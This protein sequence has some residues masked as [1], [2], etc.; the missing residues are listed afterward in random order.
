[1]STSLISI[2]IPAYNEEKNIDLAYHAIEDVFT[3]K[4]KEY[5]FEVVFV[6]DGS[7]DSTLDKIEALEKKYPETVRVVS[8][9][10]NFGKEIAVTAG[11]HS[12]EGDACILFDCDLQYP[13]EYIPEFVQNWSK[14]Y[15]V[16]VGLR[17][18]KKEKSTILRLGSMFYGIVLRS[19]ANDIDKDA[20][21]FRLLDRKVIDVFKSLSE[22]NRATRNLID[23]LGFKRA[24]VR[25]VE[26]PRVNGKSVMDLKQR[27]RLAMNSFVSCSFKPLKFAGY[28]GIIIT[29]TSLLLAMV[30]LINK[31]V[32]NDPF[33][34][35][36]S[37]LGIL[38][39][40][41][42]FFTGTILICLGLI[43]LY[44][45]N[46]TTEVL[47]RPLYIIRKSSQKRT[48]RSHAGL[49][50]EELWHLDEVH[51]MAEVIVRE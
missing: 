34:L 38:T 33:R 25:Y 41:N 45:A 27:T 48:P 18:R 5:K 4:L 13:P 43:A 36:I 7:A 40:I 21:D 8:L 28:L 26:K 19:I 44:I 14:G 16:V 11:I 12:C 2:I 1:M 20:L 47:G 29:C 31:Y 46:I 39:I 35:N 3:N 24:Y 42:M 22:R 17:D 50:S 23:W 30:G 15:D 51:P 6:D 32:F 49:K 9:S 37:S 10:R